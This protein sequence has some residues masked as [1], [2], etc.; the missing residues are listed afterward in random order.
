MTDQPVEKPIPV[1]AVKVPTV[2][3][4]KT[5]KTG[6]LKPKPAQIKPETTYYNPQ[7]S[8]LLEMELT[9][10]AAEPVKKAEPMANKPKKNV[11][12]IEIKPESTFYKPSKS[13]L[14][15]Q[16]L[17]RAE[18]PKTP[19]K[20]DP[21]PVPQ[22]LKESTELAKSD[23]GPVKGFTMVK[24]PPVGRQVKTKKPKAPAVSPPPRPAL[25]VTGDTDQPKVS[26][27]KAKTTSPTATKN[28]TTVAQ[29]PAVE[30][31]K[32]D[33]KAT[34]RF[35]RQPS[36]P[37]RLRGT[38]VAE[39]PKRMV[40]KYQSSN[41]RDPFATLA[42]E[43]RSEANYSFENR[44]LDIETARLVGVLESSS[45]KYRAL[46]EDLDGFGFILKSG[47]RIKKGYVSKIYSDK[48]MFQL[49]EYGW[50]RSHALRLGDNE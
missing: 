37:A 36:I 11:P 35:R 16:E 42:T 2:A 38:I 41:F 3:V 1:L 15:E 45:G 28:T 22:V 43:K 48:A 26:T 20:K 47:D 7:R 50:S 9:Q 24:K 31:V 49:F 18:L 14:I 25:V 33:N 32:K 13:T 44:L 40:I 10:T 39:F 8:S 23:L 19:A 12:Q 30:K 27:P 5:N 21:A 17:A 34:S 6:E 46:V 4:N 29:K